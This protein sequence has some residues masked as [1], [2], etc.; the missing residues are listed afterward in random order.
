MAKARGEPQIL[1]KVEGAERLL[2]TAVHLFFEKGDMLS[3]HALSSAAHEVLHVLLKT[4]GKKVSLMKD[5]PVVRPDKQKEWHDALQRTQNF[6][7]HASRD[8]RATLTYYEV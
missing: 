2:R 1:T 3:I 8:L 6:L 4:S 7:K 5:N